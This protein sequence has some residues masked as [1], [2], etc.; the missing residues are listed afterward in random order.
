MGMGSQPGT[1]FDAGVLKSLV[2]FQFQ[3]FATPRLIRILYAISFVIICLYGLFFLFGGLSQGGFVAVLSLLG[4]PLFVLLGLLY[5]RVMT[6]V[7]AVLFRLGENTTRMVA[8]LEAGAGPGGAG[9]GGA[10]GVGPGGN[11]WQGGGPP[12]PGSGQQPPPSPSV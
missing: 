5:A 1:S 3:S 12:G 6:E 10:P 4:A 9:R 11:P 8:L 7:I 2:D